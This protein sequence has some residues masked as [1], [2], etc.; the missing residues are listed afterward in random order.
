MKRL[1]YIYSE[2]E[3]MWAVTVDGEERGYVVT[4]PRDWFVCFDPALYAWIDQNGETHPIGWPGVPPDPLRSTFKPEPEPEPRITWD[5]LYLY[6]AQL[7]AQRSTCQRRKVGAVVVSQDGM[8]H[9]FGY[10]E[11]PAGAP[12]CPGVMVCTH[13]KGSGCS[14]TVHAEAN[15]LLKANR[16]KLQGGTMYLTLSPCP[17]CCGLIIN[18][19]VAR[20]VYVE[21]YPTIDESR[22]LL[23]RAGVAL[24]QHDGE[25]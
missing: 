5:H 25:S 11:G 13:G 15:A 7:V 20:V 23:E 6:M 24:E 17:S 21:E 4:P 18:A 16:D 8:D 9:W 2:S 1:N 19:G 12:H 10:N 22:A 14:Y 3:G